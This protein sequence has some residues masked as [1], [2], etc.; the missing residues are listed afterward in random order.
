[1]IANLLEE[2]NIPYHYEIALQLGT[3]TKYPDFV[4]KNPYTGKTIIWEHFGALDQP[5]YEKNMNDKMQL[6]QKHGYKAFENLIYTF[7]F[8]MMNNQCRLKDLIEQI[9]L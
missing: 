7:E 6:Y 9:I 5:V 2:Y 4:I 1:M 3:Q 8:D